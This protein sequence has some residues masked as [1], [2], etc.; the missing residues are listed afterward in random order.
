MRD[1]PEV[2]NAGGAE[3]VKTVAPSAQAA[4]RHGKQQ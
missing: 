3:L 2:P 4:L 1:V